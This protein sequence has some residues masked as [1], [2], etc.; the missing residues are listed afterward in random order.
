MEQGLSPAQVERRLR[1]RA[2][3]ILWRVARIAEPGLIPWYPDFTHAANGMTGYHSPEPAWGAAGSLS[4]EALAAMRD[5]TAAEYAKQRAKERRI[6][7]RMKSRPDQT[8]FVALMFAYMA[9]CLK[10][11]PERPWPRHFE[12]EARRE[13]EAACTS[14]DDPN[15]T[16]ALHRALFAMTRAQRELARAIAFEVC[17]PVKAAEERAN[18]AP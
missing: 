4:D 17:R 10:G 1:R 9:Q 12:K 16:D 7:A 15:N 5:L 6:L 18:K 8:A 2:D 11:T 3:A 14:P 13:A